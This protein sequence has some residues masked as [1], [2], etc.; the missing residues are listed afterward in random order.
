MVCPALEGIVEA[1]RESIV[2]D[3]DAPLREADG[4]RARELQKENSCSVVCP[5]PRVGSERWTGLNG[6][7]QM[8]PG[9]SQGEQRATHSKPYL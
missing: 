5:P 1:P 4:G 8:H 3:L 2:E 7:H 6:I 9:G